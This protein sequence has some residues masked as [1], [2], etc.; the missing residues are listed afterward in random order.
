MEKWFRR[1]VLNSLWQ[2]LLNPTEILLLYWSV[3]ITK[4]LSA[5]LCG[6][7]HTNLQIFCPVFTTAVY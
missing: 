2:I 5:C 6:Y 4:Q 7:P 3:W 1:Q